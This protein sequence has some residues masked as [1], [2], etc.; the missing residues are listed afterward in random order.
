MC[1]RLA[2]AARALSALCP[3]TSDTPVIFEELSGDVDE[4]FFVTS[5][6]VEL[7]KSVELVDVSAAAEGSSNPPP[8]LKEIPPPR[9]YSSL[10]VHTP[11][12][13]TTS[14]PSS[15]TSSRRKPGVDKPR[16]LQRQGSTRRLD[17]AVASWNSP[18]AKCL[19][20]NDDPL[21]FLK[22]KLE[23]VREGSQ[24]VGRVHKAAADE[25]KVRRGGGRAHAS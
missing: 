16:A 21:P 4:M 20:G 23:G 6:S 3:L 24:R 8:Q 7:F 2:C 11:L 15:A 5:G 1:R 13:L 10:D 17:A 18:I 22:R 12:S 19:S 25:G 9:S 14:D